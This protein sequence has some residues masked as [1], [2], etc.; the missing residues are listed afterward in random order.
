MDEDAL[1]KLLKR[2]TK[3]TLLGL[4]SS[5]YHETNTQQRYDIFGDLMKVSKKPSK[6]LAHDI[7]QE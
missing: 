2:Q 1:F 4:L 6:N 7:L 5:T 3:A